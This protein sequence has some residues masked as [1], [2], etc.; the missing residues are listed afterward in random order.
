MT[1]EDGHSPDPPDQPDRPQNNTPPAPSLL[2]RLGR[3][4]L[5]S[6]RK[7][8]ATD[9]ELRAASFA[10][11]AFFA[12]FPLLLLFISIGGWVLSDSEQK[13]ETKVLE[14]VSNYVPVGQGGS[15]LIA[16]TIGGVVASR[17]TAG[18]V[19]ILALTWSSLRFF[20]SLVQGI[21]RAWG[22][23]EYSWWRLP[24]ANLSMVGITGSTLLLGLVAPLIMR[25]IE[26]Y[27]QRSGVVGFELLEISF[28]TARLFLP[29]LI[30]F[31]GL[32]MFYK[33]AP[34]RKTTIREVWIAALVATIAL[35]VVAKGIVVYADNFARFNTLYGALGSVVVVLM[36]I[37][38]SGSVLIFCGCLCAAQSEV[39]GKPD[40]QK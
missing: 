39:F 1:T 12:L 5:V 11:Y 15:N 2:R 6:V 37:Y 7:Y 14:L 28:R 4:L 40:G 30:L 8:V 3:L 20:Q 9:G 13:V 31:Y 25:A 19:A 16:S 10:Y 35:Q 26:S 23:K 33:Y 32:L 29:S 34:R 17:G 22:L 38:L 36:W 18:I 24:L 27:W 21:N